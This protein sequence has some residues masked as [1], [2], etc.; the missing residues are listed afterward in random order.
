MGHQIPRSSRKIIGTKVVRFVHFHP[1]AQSRVQAFFDGGKHQQV[2]LVDAKKRSVTVSM[3]A[4]A[5]GRRVLWASPHNGAPRMRMDGGRHHPPLV[6]SFANHAARLVFLALRM[7]QQ[8]V[9]CPTRKLVLGEG[10]WPMKPMQD[11][12]AN[13]L[14]IRFRQERRFL[15]LRATHPKP[16][17]EKARAPVHHPPLLGER[18][19]LCLSLRPSRSSVVRKFM[20]VRLVLQ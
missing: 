12:N 6:F 7:S 3:N 15:G 14:S 20:F 13:G 11:V 19:I 4:D 8:H 1:L 5:R 16:Q 10:G 18:P 9:S 2:G 17:E